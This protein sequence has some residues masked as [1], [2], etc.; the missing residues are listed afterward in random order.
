MFRPS[1]GFVYLTNQQGTGA[2]EISFHYG[3]G[4]D[5]PLVGDWDGD[6]CDSLAIYRPGESRFY[7]SNSNKTQPADFS[8]NFG[9]VGDRPLSGDFNGD[10]RDDFGL[11]RPDTGLV[12][13]V[14]E[15]AGPADLTFYFGAPGDTLIVGDWDGDGIDT[16]GVH[17]NDEGRWYFRL[18]N[19][20]GTADH[21]LRAGP[22]T[23][24][25]D[26]VVGVW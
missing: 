25:V 12:R 23:E 5:I 26:P 14:F 10:G 24:L 4:G 16:L 8:F 15:Q 7:G 22:R 17:R 20:T 3:I 19:S 11:H 2:A 21:V 13:V 9:R 1:N 18:E 6:G